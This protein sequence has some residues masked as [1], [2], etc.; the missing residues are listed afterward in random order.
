MYTAGVL[1]FCGLF[2]IFCS[3]MNFEWF[4]GSRKARLFVKL[5]GRGGTRVFYIILGLLCVVVAVGMI[6]EG[7]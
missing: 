2:A 6:I 7:V 1:L 3:A 5:F 4:I